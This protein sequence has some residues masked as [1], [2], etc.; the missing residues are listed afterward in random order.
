MKV[1]VT[2]EGGSGGGAVGQWWGGGII[3]SLSGIN[4]EKKKSGR[5]G[6]LFGSVCVAMMKW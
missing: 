5:K 2:V 1:T 4:S 6:T 3:Q